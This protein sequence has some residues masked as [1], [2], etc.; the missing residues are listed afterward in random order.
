M[1]QKRIW[2]PWRMAYIAGD[3]GAAGAAAEPSAWLDGADRHCFLCRAAAQYA[4]EAAAR[5]ESLVVRTG[6]RTVTLL[7]RYPY[8]NGHLLL[9]PRR[10][11]GA[12]HELSDDEHLEAARTLVHFTVRL[13]EL[14]RAEGFNIGLNLG[15][16]AGAGV[17]GHLHWHLVP[18]WQGDA[19]FMPVTADA[20]VISQSLEA[21]WQ[22]VVED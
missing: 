8:N 18:R 11:V 22:A 21:L 4:D 1:D 6:E 20:R 15:R 12:F 7:N 16:V 19:N 13:S 2:A 9:A 3:G 10:H 5:R 17:P 14:I